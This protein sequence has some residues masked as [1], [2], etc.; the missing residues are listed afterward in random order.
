[1]S[2]QS[3]P[4]TGIVSVIDAMRS[5]QT[6]GDRWHL[7]EVLLA[8]VPTGYNGLPQIIDQAT[9]AGVAGSLSVNTLRLY[10][11]TAARWPADQ[12]V[13]N[14][15]FSA[16]REAMVLPTI[17]A[18]AKMLGD[19][20]AN[21]GPSKVTVASVR[22]AIAV[23]QGRP[24]PGSKPGSSTPTSQRAVD[25]LADLIAGGPQLI[26]AIPATTE[27]SVLDQLHAGLTKAISHV[28][29]LRAKAARKAAKSTTTPSTPAA[30]KAPRTNSKRTGDLRGL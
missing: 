4:T 12:R 17:A 11:D 3:I 29:R 27:A 25:V 9:A 20:A 16:H 21:L 18:A 13:A 24:V 30:V 22:K 26:A 8:Q 7:A 1:M 14:V 6:E 23:Q 10:R 5:L 2:Q 19:L 15:S 28:E